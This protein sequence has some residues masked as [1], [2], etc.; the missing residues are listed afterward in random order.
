MLETEKGKAK[1][2]STQFIEEALK[3]NLEKYRQKALELGASQAEVIPAQWVQVDERVRLKCSIPPCPNYGRCGN[4][5]P[6]TPEPEFMRKAFKRF[7]WAVLFETD[8]LVEDFADI[9]RYY[10][11]GQRHQRQTDEIAGKVETMAFADGYQFAM[12]FGA[13]GC[14]D[15]FCNG[16][17]CHMLD[18]G[19]CPH[20]LRS[21]PSMEGIGIDVFALVNRVGW[22]IFPIYR[23]VDPNLVPS[24]ISVGIVFI[25]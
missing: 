19:R 9:A 1:V 13:G 18:S 5:P 16:G 7:N 8:V 6:Y 4:C 23:S 25:Q 22:K 12:G 14:R 10:P 2:V 17:L 20:I 3:V 24:A 21:R 15:T 11:H